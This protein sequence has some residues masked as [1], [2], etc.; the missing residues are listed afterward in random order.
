MHEKCQQ[1][2]LQYGNMYIIYY[3][4][5]HCEVRIRTADICEPI[6]SKHTEEDKLHRFALALF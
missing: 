4:T 1:Y 3:F 5:H 6:W 2:T